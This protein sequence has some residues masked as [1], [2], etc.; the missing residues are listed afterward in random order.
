[1]VVD[2]ATTYVVILWN[3]LRSFNGLRAPGTVEWTL[4]EWAER[5]QGYLLAREEL[6]RAAA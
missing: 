5:C 4:V 1:M 2:M 6:S 3:P